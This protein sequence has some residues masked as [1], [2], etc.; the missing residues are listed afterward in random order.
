M[1]FKMTGLLMEKK[2]SELIKKVYKLLLTILLSRAIMASLE[3][4][5]SIEIK[6]GN[7]ENFITI[8]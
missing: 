3:I 8:I 2:S 7:F 5:V 4:L 1:N 6:N